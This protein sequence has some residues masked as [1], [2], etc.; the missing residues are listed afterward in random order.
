MVGEP[1]T[2]NAGPGDRFL[3]ADSLAQP[4]GGTHGDL[5][6]NALSGPTQW[7]FDVAL[8][9]NF[10]LTEAQRL[11]FRVEAYNLTNSFRALDPAVRLNQSTF[12]LIRNSDEPRILQF[13]IKYLF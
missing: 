2:G 6:W 5:G 13:A 12:G 11:E 4:A 3:S 10:T 8:S 7:Q 1:Y 9:R